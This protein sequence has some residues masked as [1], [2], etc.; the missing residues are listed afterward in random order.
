MGWASLRC[1]GRLLLPHSCLSSLQ[2]LCPCVG[3]VGV[4]RLGLVSLLLLVTLVC[5]VLRLTLMLAS[6]WVVVAPR[7]NV[8]SCAFIGIVSQGLARPCSSDLSV[9][10]QTETEPVVGFADGRKKIWG[11]PAAF[12]EEMLY[13]V[14]PSNAE[15]S[16]FTCLGE[17]KQPCPRSLRVRGFV[18]RFF[19]I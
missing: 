10:P 19:L 5:F 1:G 3:C 16:V 8:A 15:H 4:R 2:H 11:F 7:W 18:R 6:R 17:I 12:R 9:S 14:A 13:R